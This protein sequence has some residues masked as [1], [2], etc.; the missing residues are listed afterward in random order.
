VWT[1]DITYIATD[2]GW[3]YLTV[4]LDLY[5]RQ[6]VGWSMKEHMPASLVVD[7]LRRR[8]FAGNLRPG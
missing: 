2:E 6:V 3:F 8:P 1:T 5:S 7:A 4:L